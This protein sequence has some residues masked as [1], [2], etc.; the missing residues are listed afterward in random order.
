MAGISGK[1]ERRG[2]VAGY[3]RGD[4]ATGAGFEGERC[5]SGGDGGGGPVVGRVLEC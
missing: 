4:D 1:E 5:F 3:G 2:C